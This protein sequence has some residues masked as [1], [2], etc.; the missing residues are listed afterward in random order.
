MLRLLT[1]SFLA[2]SEFGLTL[3]DLPRF[4]Q[5]NQWSQSHLARTKHPEITEY[6]NLE[7]PK[8]DG[9]I[10]Q[11]VTPVLNKI[12]PL[13][14]DPE[15]RLML[16]TQSTINFR[17]IL[18]QNLVMLVN[19][20][21]G[22]LGEG[23]SALM[24]AF[25]VAHLQ[26]AALARANSFQRKPFY[27]YLD[28]FQNYTTDNIK[29]ILS[30]SRKYALS[31]IMAHQYLAQLAEDL[32]GAVLNTAGSIV[33]FRIG[34]HDASDLCRELFLL[35]S[36]T[37]SRQEIEMGHFDGLLMPYVRERTEPLDRDALASLL[38]QLRPREFWMKQRGPYAPTKQRALDVPDPRLSKELFQAR[39]ELVDISGSRYGK[40]KSEVRKEMNARRTNG[41]GHSS[42]P[43]DYYETI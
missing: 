38:T 40:L 36:L 30:E 24:G 7:F 35:G 19:L 12:G 18:D 22:V 23:N 17:K 10:H 42:R 26:Q 43:T 14:F 5:D 4:L 32:R 28:E 21:K 31:L 13:I 16:S 6:F 11:W 1:F 29:D 8:K 34:Y 9:A 39:K 2:L 27:L 37:T 25:V 41:S 15:M 3:A 33:C 20:P